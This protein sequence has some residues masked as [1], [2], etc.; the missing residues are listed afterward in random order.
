M[1]SDTMNSFTVAKKSKASVNTV[2]DF[3]IPWFALE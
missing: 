3:V 2:I 1:S